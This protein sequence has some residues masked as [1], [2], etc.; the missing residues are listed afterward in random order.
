M[1]SKLAE[2]LV[3]AFYTPELHE[4]FEEKK[5]GSDGKCLHPQGPMRGCAKWKCGTEKCPREL[6]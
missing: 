4:V 6:K 2:A 3:S 5:S 1:K